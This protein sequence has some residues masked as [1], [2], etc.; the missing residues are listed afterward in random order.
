MRTAER[1]CYLRFGVFGV[2]DVVVEVR[3]DRNVLQRNVLQTDKF[4]TLEF[5]PKRAVGLP[6]PFPN[7]SLRAW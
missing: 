1:L 7:A 3:A 2:E 4:P 6:S 5:V